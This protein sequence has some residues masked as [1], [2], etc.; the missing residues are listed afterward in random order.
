MHSF[1]LRHL[2]AYLQNFSLS[3]ICLCNRNNTAWVTRVTEI[4]SSYL[5]EEAGKILDISHQA[6]GVMWEDLLA[7]RA[8]ENG[9]RSEEEKGLCNEG[10]LFYSVH[11]DGK[12]VKGKWCHVGCHGNRCSGSAVAYR[13]GVSSLGLEPNCKDTSSCPQMHPMLSTLLI[14]V[15]FLFNINSFMTFLW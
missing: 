14:F 7:E 13:W 15:G 10:T 1:L 5:L 9:E 8:S 11:E 2:K 3:W 6:S 12:R 4:I